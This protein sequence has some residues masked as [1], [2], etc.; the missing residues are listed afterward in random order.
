MINHRKDKTKTTEL[1]PGMIK[2]VRIEQLRVLRISEK[3][4]LQ[5][6]MLKQVTDKSVL[7]VHS[8][9]TSL[10]KH[11]I[12]YVKIPWPLHDKYSKYIGGILQP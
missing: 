9:F 7:H 6:I 4:M 2:T 10:N 11:I 12:K 1:G 8:Y 5:L 3:N